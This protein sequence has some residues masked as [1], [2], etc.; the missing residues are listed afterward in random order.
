MLWFGAEWPGYFGD[1]VKG[2][3]FTICKVARGR[4]SNATGRNFTLDHN[5]HQV[6]LAGVLAL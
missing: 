1:S 6:F 4:A 3:L 5:D 2:C